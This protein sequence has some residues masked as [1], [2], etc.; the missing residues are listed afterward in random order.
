VG[1]FAALVVL[2]RWWIPQ[3]PLGAWEEVPRSLT[4]GALF[5]A[6][7]APLPLFFERRLRFLQSLREERARGSG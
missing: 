5:L 7:G 1:Y 3:T 4:E 2:I 6:V